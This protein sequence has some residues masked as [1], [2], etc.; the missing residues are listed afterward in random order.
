MKFPLNKEKASHYRDAF[1]LL[2]QIS[3]EPT[4]ADFPFYIEKLR[5]EPER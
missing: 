1:S 3:S 4:A 2:I 5:L